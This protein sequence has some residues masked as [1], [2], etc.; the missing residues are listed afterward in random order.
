MEIGFIG[1]GHMGQAIARN[2]LKTGHRV[3]V[4]NRTRAKS[5]DVAKDGATIAE[6]PAG[7]AANAEVLFT[8]LAD[9]AAVEGVLYGKEGAAAALARD[10]L[11]VSLSTISVALSRSLAERHGEAGQFYVAAPVLGRPDAAAEGKLFV[12]AAGKKAAVERARPL[13]EAIGQKLFVLDERPESANL[14]KLGANFLLAAMLESLGEVFALTRKAGIDPQH[15]LDILTTSMF[16]APAY[17]NYGGMIVADKFEPAG[18][19]MPM[20]L[21]DVGLALDA[22]KA[23]AVPMPFASLLR[24]RF[25]EGMAAGLEKSEWAAIARIAA[26]DAGL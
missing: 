25:V 24:E 22:A 10:K 16:P 21:K 18:F 9:D 13:L 8:M 14:A 15:Y 5:E 4:H 11:H 1:L 20:G 23:L 17:K 7:A 19:A 3:T 2:L 6:K 26:R 12:V